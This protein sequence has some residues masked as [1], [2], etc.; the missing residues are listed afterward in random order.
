MTSRLTD[1]ADIVAK[2][3]DALLHRGDI[4][5]ASRGEI[6]LSLSSLADKVSLAKADR[7]TDHLARV[8]GAIDMLERAKAEHHTDKIDPLVEQIKD[9]VARGETEP[10]DLLSLES[11]LHEVRCHLEEHVH[12][13]K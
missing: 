4:S 9:A 11:K 2:S 5:P 10:S 6:M 3:F 13:K 8:R 1:A 7:V 12:G